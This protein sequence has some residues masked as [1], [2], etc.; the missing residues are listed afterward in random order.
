VRSCKFVAKYFAHVNERIN[1][2]NPFGR[3]EH[4]IR[5]DCRVDKRARNEGKY[6]NVDP[7]HSP[8]SLLPFFM[9]CS[10]SQRR[11][12]NIEI[13]DNNGQIL[14]GVWQHGDMT[15]SDIYRYMELFMTPQTGDLVFFQTDATLEN[16][17][18]PLLRNYEIIPQPLFLRIG[19][20]GKFLVLMLVNG[21]KVTVDL[22]SIFPQRVGRTPT[23]TRNM[24]QVFLIL[25]MVYTF[26]RF[27]RFNVRG[28]DN[29]MDNV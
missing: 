15:N 21:K 16:V 13:Y 18:Q 3:C 5:N 4:S 20:N 1:D 26:Y 2:R 10:F 28:V 6:S 19:V 29:A 9:H 7:P 22:T 23:D 27:Y 25:S 11:Y 24:D 8:L 17:G 14:G 12:R